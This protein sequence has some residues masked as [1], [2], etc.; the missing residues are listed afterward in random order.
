MVE[1]QRLLQLTPMMGVLVAQVVVEE[2]QANVAQVVQEILL[3]QVR[4]K[5]LMVV[6]QYHLLRLPIMELVGAADLLKQ[7]L[8]GLLLLVAEEV[9][10][11]QLVLQQV[12]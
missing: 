8:M 2:A 6:M 7:V 12:L 10:V 9:L 3:Q 11:Q 1:M 5:D 4:L